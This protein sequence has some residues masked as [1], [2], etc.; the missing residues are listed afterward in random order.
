[1]KVCEILF[2]VCVMLLVQGCQMIEQQHP[3]KGNNILDSPSAHP[4]LEGAAQ[5]SIMKT[6]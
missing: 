3:K 5:S 4:E 2:G 6:L 1:M